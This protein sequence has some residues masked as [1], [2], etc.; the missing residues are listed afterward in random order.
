MTPAS[1][2]SLKTLLEHAEGERDAAQAALREAEALA[3][4]H[5]DQASELQS[6][7]AQFQAR[8]TAQ[9]R[10]PTVPALLQ[11]HHGFSQRLDQAIAQQDAQC[12]Q[13][14]Q[15]VARAHEQLRR[16]EQRVAA[17]RKLIE[18]RLAAQQRLA[19]R[20]DQKQTDEAAQRA[21]W[22]RAISADIT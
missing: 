14:G 16:C 2:Q 20:R 12:R 21:A 3:R 1:L 22:A 7:R 6:Y 13:Q 19:Q 11:C 5:A 4:R 18:R 9:F 8:W 10:Q 17:V 15:R